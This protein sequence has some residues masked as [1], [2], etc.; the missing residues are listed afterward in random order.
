MY[1]KLSTIL[2]HTYNCHISKDKLYLSTFL[3][4]YQDYFNNMILAWF[5]T[6]VEPFPRSGLFTEQYL[7]KITYIYLINILSDK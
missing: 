2:L 1:P 3:G 5:E 7:P 4:K 6:K